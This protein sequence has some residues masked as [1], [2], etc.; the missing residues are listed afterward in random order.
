VRRKRSLRECFS[1]LSDFLAVAIFC[2]F[3][4]FSF[5]LKMPTK[6]ETTIANFC[7]YYLKTRG[8]VKQHISSFDYFINEDVKKIVS[9]NAIVRSD[10]SPLFYLK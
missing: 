3:D 8:L 9:V 6:K 4:V 2:R 7:P 10:A 1:W 5:A